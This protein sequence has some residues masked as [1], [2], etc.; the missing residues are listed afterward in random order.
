MFRTIL[1]PAFAALVCA[2]TSLNVNISSVVLESGEA[3]QIQVTWPS[4]EHA[5]YTVS[6]RP[7]WLNVSSA[8]NYKAPDTLSIQIASSYCGACTA[9]ILLVP[10][11]GGPPTP[12]SVT[13]KSESISDLRV[14]ATP[15]TVTLVNS[16]ARSIR[17]AGPRGSAMEYLVKDAPPWLSVT[18]TH[19]FTTPDTL[20][21]QLATSLCG[22]CRATL[23]LAPSLGG[24]TTTV[25]VV[26]DTYGASSYHLASNRVTL[27][28]PAPPGAACSSGYFSS[29]SIEISSTNAKVSTYNAKVTST[30]GGN[31]LSINKTGSAVA[32]A[33]VAN[34]LILSIDET[35]AG[36]LA[37][38]EYAAQVLLYNPANQ[39]DLAMVHVSLLLS[40]GKMTVAPSTGAGISQSFVV[41]FPHPGGWEN[42]SVVNLFFTTGLEAR[43]ACLLAYL[44]SE[45]KLMLMDDSGNEPAADN[46]TNSQCTAKLTSAEGSGSILTL[47]FAVTFKPAFVGKKM[48]YMAERDRSENNSG[49]IEMGNWEVKPPPVRRTL[50]AKKK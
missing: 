37:P 6:N 38:G 1:L 3:K 45:K 24:K 36:A 2:Q 10:A 47:K 11:G 5:G 46:Q 39:S 48:I 9:T 12:V 30:Q 44:V 19:N 4:E 35:A 28:S 27:T 26:F 15:A 29:C 23:T 31:W 33:P 8:N 43:R 32:G 49:W 14:T 18:S 42:L 13:Y 21:F 7:P 20:S 34:G 50:P 41:Q 22:T 17:I 16:E 40:P 25:E